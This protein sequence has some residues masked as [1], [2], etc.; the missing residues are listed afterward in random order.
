VGANVTVIPAL[1]H[2]LTVGRVGHPLT[3]LH[4]R[5]LETQKDVN[6]VMNDV[7]AKIGCVPKALIYLTEENMQTKNF[8]LYRN[9]ALAFSE[10]I[11][12]QT[13]RTRPDDMEQE[14]L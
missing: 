8:W 4:I 2:G 1:I 5:S 6:A 14:R 3:S 12:Q 9:D 10:G 13:M 7:G 11:I